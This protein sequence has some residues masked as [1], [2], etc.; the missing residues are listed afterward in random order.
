[1]DVSDAQG[2]NIRVDARGNEVRSP[3]SVAV[4]KAGLELSSPIPK[5][6]AF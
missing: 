3:V 6:P 1:M 2:S 4:V 5:P